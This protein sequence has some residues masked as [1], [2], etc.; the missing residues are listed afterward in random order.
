M[1][2]L[3]IGFAVV[4]S[5]MLAMDLGVFGGAGVM[6]ARRAWRWTVRWIGL[7]LAFTGVVYAAYEFGWHGVSEG[8]QGGTAAI[9][10]LTAY[11][12]E[13]SLSVDNLVVIA[14][15]FTRWSIPRDQQHRVLYW[16]VI[17]A[18]AARTALIVGGV[19]I[20]NHIDWVFYV[21][22]AYLAFT[23]F[24]MVRP[25]TSEKAEDGITARLVNAVVPVSWTAAPVTFFARDGKGRRVATRMLVALVA[26]ETA[27]LVFAM[28]S[29][30]AALAVSTDPFIVLTSN[31]FAI[32]GLRALYFVLVDVLDRFEHL[33]LALAGLLLFIAAKMLLHGVIHLPNWVSLAVVVGAFTIG[34]LASGRSKP[35]DDT[36][37]DDTPPDE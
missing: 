2:A 33:N 3:W 12:L 19:W 22:G 6:D 7:G 27:D 32:L 17:G 29:I 8:G 1:I 26:V 9:H 18:V 11:L 28:D 4:V 16:G 37:P 21:F 23:A 15:V 25:H 35:T 5:V 13:K 14:L 10:Y 24:R 20:V 31:I 34:V 36:P 30:P